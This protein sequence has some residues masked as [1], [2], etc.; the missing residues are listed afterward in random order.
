[1]T[2]FRSPFKSLPIIND[3]KDGTIRSSSEGPTSKADNT[4]PVVCFFHVIHLLY[5]YKR[6]S[7]VIASFLSLQCYTYVYK[8]IYMCY[9]TFIIKLV[10]FC[11]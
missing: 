9:K 2:I 8:R 6:I 4:L 3:T 5:E 10:I 1:M 7:C 11:V